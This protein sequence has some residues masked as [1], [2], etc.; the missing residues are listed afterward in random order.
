MLD[1]PR[2]TVFLVLTRPKGF[3]DLRGLVNQR[4][5]AWLTNPLNYK[6]CFLQ[7]SKKWIYVTVLIALYGFLKN[8][9]PESTYMAEF[10]VGPRFNFTREQVR[11]KFVVIRNVL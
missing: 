3:F 7:G 9:S 6:K 10:F 4:T 11:F 1:F 2:I 5:Q 8:I